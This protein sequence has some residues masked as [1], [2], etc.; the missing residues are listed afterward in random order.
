MHS[1]I[2]NVFLQHEIKV[3]HLN[4]WVTAPHAPRLVIA[5]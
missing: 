1:E 5:L 3:Q 2:Q 4:L